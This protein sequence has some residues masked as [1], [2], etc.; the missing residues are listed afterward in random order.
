[1][2]EIGALKRIADKQSR[3]ASK[4]WIR[5][6][7]VAFVWCFLSTPNLQWKIDLW[8]QKQRTNIRGFLGNNCF[9]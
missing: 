5:L 8:R 3:L 6:G 9:S 7:A 4:E 1:M 2:R